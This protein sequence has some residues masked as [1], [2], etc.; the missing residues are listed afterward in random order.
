MMWVGDNLLEMMNGQLDAFLPMNGQLDTALAWASQMIFA[1]QIAAV[2]IGLLVCFF[3]LKLIRVLSAISGLAVGAVL[4]TAAAFGFRFSG[5]MIP[6]TILVCAVV[7]AVL[8]VGIRKMGVFFVIFLYTAG[9]VLSLNIPQPMIL[10][11]VCGAAA[12]LAA[13]LSMI[14]TDPVVVVITG[15]SG[16]LSAGISAAALLGMDGNILFRYGIGAVLALLGILTQFMIQ[17]RKIGKKEKV[18]ASQMRNQVSRE[19][20]VEKARRILEDDEEEDEESDIRTAKS[21]R[22]T[23]AGRKKKVSKK[24]SAKSVKSDDMEEDDDI[25]IINEDL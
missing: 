20:E 9:I 2:V 24:V 22:K 7:V 19:S 23:K 15:V 5:T 8:A 17:S 18:Y 14:W 1:M 21:I 11:I 13:V 4:G 10:L 12:L 6:V 16:G 25:T 3:G